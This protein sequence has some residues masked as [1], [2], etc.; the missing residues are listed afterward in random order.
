[1]DTKQ[2][3]HST[4]KNGEEKKINING[5][6]F[7]GKKIVLIAGPCAVESLAQLDDT[8]SKLNKVDVIRGGAFK[9]RTSPYDFTGLE[10][11]GISILENVSMKYNKLFVTEMTNLSLIDL[12]KKDVDIIQVGARD[13]Q[14]FELLKLLGKSN[15]PVI[16][17]RGF[18]NTIEELL[19]ASEYILKEGNQ[20][21][22]LCERG[23]RTFENSTRFTLDLSAIPVIKK[24]SNLPV[25][26]DPSHA[27]GNSEY[28][29]SLSLAAI[30]AGADGLMIEVHCNPEQALSD[31]EQALTPGQYN[32]LVEKIEK[33]AEAVG[34]N[35]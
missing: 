19:D 27:A 4:K 14:N 28:I 16:L 23:I 7:G 8:I 1:M 13:M 2:L 21:V 6:V 29:E 5:V 25:I 26:V 11:E 30:A 32:N 3:I 33:V 15:K 22:I 17:K 31:K 9:P 12:Y 24:Y 34:R 20:N 10:E 18:G 35:L